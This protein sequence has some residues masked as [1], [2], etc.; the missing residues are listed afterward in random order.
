MN[1]VYRIIWNDI[2]RSWV[3]VAETVKSC[4]KRSH[5]A[6]G[7][8]G[9][10]QHAERSALPKDLLPPILRILAASLA[11]IGT[12]VWALDT[13]ALPT[14]G[15]VTAGSAAINQIGTTLNIQQNTQRA[16]LDWQSLNI[17]AAATVIFA[18][19]I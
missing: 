18:S 6:V 14:G 10:Q 16:A 15:K 3:A 1:H 9:G 4:G 5:S 19:V 2:T 17:G 12:P 8:T 13:N 11:L 7:A